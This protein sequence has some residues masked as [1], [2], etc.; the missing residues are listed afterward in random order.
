MWCV[1]V[2][3]RYRFITEKNK[4]LRGILLRVPSYCSLSSKLI[5][6]CASVNVH[7]YWDFIYFMFENIL[8]KDRYWYYINKWYTWK[9]TLVTL[10][11]GIWL[12]SILSAVVKY[13]I[14][15]FLIFMMLL[16]WILLWLLRVVMFI[17]YL[18]SL[19]IMS[20]NNKPNTLLSNLITIL[21]RV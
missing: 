15:N 2:R 4:N 16:L 13:F 3:E 12:F 1:C 14:L 6:K 11:F 5:G 8:H 10:T 9:L 19:E 17:F 18:F 20:L 21:Y 7:L